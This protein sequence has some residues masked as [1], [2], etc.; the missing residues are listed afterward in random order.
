MR[1]ITIATFLITSLIFAG[2]KQADKLQADFNKS[3]ENVKKETANIKEKI[4]STKKSIETNVQKVENL[5][6]AVKAFSDDEGA[7]PEEEK[8]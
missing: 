3:V 8:K 4:D 6:N 5:V 7:K 2:C 1:K